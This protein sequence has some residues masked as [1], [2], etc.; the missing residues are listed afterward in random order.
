[1]TRISC[2]LSPASRSDENFC[3]AASVALAMIA[4]LWNV[5]IG[6]RC[7]SPG[8]IVQINND[9]VAAL[10]CL[11]KIARICNGDGKADNWVDLAGYAAIGGEIQARG[12]TPAE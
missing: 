2:F 8:A 6:Q 12:E 10:M 11:F 1:M 4:D 7:A 5:Y 9:D 3:D